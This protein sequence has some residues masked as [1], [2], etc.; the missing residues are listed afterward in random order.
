[1]KQNLR[2]VVER[3]A[4]F[5]G[6]RL[7]PEVLSSIT[8]QS[9]FSSMKDN[10]S[11]NYSWQNKDRNDGSVT[12]IRKGQVGDW[13]NHFSNEQLKRFDAE[14]YRRIAGTGLSFDFSQQQ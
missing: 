3:V 4:V 9:T 5:M 12:F 1:M 11:A 6:Y 2:E 8:K 14:Y 10:P 13:V 7:T